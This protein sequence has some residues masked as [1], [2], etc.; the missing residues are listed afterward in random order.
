MAMPHGR[1]YQQ[2]AALMSAVSP[3]RGASFV[4]SIPAANTTI[5]VPAKQAELDRCEVQTFDQ[6]N[7]GLPKHRESDP[8]MI[9]SRSR[10]AGKSAV[11]DQLR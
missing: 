2:A 1:R 9:G 8:P 11:G 6:G 10:P 7:R 5:T 3:K 4:A